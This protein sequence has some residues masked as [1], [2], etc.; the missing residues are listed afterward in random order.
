MAIH[1][2]H[3]RTPVG[4]LLR[5]L[6]AV[7]LLAP[8]ATL[9]GQVW[10]SESE[11]ITFAEQER[12]GIEYLSTL[13]QLTIAL[14]DAQSAAVAGKPFPRDAITKAVEATG[15]V[16]TRIG[17]RL[18]T[19]ERWSGLRA[20]IE[21][22]ASLDLADPQNAFNSYGEATDLLLALY[23][24]VRDN[25]QLTREQDA[26]AYYLQDGAAQELPESVVA[27]GRFA[28]LAVLASR[29]PRADVAAATAAL[30]TA[31]DAVISPANDLA[32][33]LQSA[34]DGTDS[35][36][37]SGNLL[38]RLDRF[39]RSMETLT[40]SSTALDGKNT[41]DA[42]PLTAARAEVQ[43]AASELAATILD[44]L[45]TLIAARLDDLTG[46][47]TL[48]LVTLL[49]AIPLAFLPLALAWFGDRRRPGTA[50][51]VTVI[52]PDAGRPPQHAVNGNRTDADDRTIERWERSGAAR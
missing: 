33:D 31:R 29:K 51:E 7:A 6:L 50:S 14:T 34:V 22:L 3:P 26:D 10:S 12:R 24:A 44:E 21:A 17:E 40:A 47:R 1:V 19:R 35:R 36:T 9:F 8:V 48:A 32:G 18:R 5:C 43:T 45:D 2:T 23:E 38:S 42:S 52:A 30:L 11:K 27:A 37:L 13:G 49:V 16:D 25:S 46:K 15:S 41:F 4:I 28:D 39:R 20:K